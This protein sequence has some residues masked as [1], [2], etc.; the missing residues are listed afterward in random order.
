MSPWGKPWWLLTGVPGEASQ[1]SF[2][3]LRGNKQ[4]ELWDNQT[5][6]VCQALGWAFYTDN[7]MKS[8]PK[9]D[10]ETEVQRDKVTYKVTQQGG[11]EASFK[12]VTWQSDVPAGPWRTRLPLGWTHPSWKPARCLPSRAWRFHFRGLAQPRGFHSAFGPVYIK[13]LVGAR[14]CV[15]PAFLSWASW[16]EPQN[17]EGDQ[18]DYVL[19]SC[20]AGT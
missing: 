10:K 14:H 5:P 15:S 1:P 6:T 13:W 8:L 12:P 3:Y 4:Q 2:P 18:S 20:K 11:K 17:T 16:S 7:L 19:G 9:S